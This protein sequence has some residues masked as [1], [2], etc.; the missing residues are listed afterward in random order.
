MSPPIPTTFDTLTKAYLPTLGRDIVYGMSRNMV[1]AFLK[2]NYPSLRHSASGQFIAMFIT[3]LAAC[4]LSSPF[5]ELRG[6]TLQPKSKQKSFGEFFKP[7]KFVRSTAVG[8]S[9]LALALATGKLVVDPVKVFLARLRQNVS[10]GVFIVLVLVFLGYNKF[11]A[12]ATVKTTTDNA[13][14]DAEPSQN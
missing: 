3:A 5:N 7:A 12:R 13:D 1:E 6:Y 10:P 11:R 14:T 4:I 9:N 8:A 2:T